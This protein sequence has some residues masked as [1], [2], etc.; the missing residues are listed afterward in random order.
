M[1]VE[2]LCIFKSLVEK[3]GLARRVEIEVGT[4]SLKSSFL[5]PSE[6]AIGREWEKVV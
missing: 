3:G 4:L 1:H 5:S 2:I 6:R